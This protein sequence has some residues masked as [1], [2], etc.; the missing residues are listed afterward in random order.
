MNIILFGVSNVGKSVTGQLLSTKL[1][2]DFY[3]LDDEVVKHLGISLEKFVHTGT[4]AWRDQIRCQLVNRIIQSKN[5]KVL[6]V[7]PLAY[8]NSI[9]YL[10]GSDDTLAI[11]LQDSPQHI[12]DRLI[13]SDE[14]DRIYKDDEYKNQHRDYYL[15]EIQKDIYFYEKNYSEIKNRFHMN[16][17]SPEVV[18]AQLIE[19]YH[20]NQQ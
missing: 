7:T 11:L 6:A 14:N 2:F 15:S 5:N 3:D 9:Q 16:G 1:G 8:I 20:L 18:V 17:N 10:F 13:F 19:T 12:F 4:L